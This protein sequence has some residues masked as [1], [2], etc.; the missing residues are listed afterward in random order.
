MPGISYRRISYTLS[1]HSTNTHWCLLSK[2]IKYRRY[3]QEEEGV[4]EQWGQTAKNL[5]ANLRRNVC[6]LVVQT[7]ERERKESGQGVSHE[8]FEMKD[9]KK[10]EDHEK[11]RTTFGTA[12][13]LVTSSA[14]IPG[15]DKALGRQNHIKKGWSIS[16]PFRDY[17]SSGLDTWMIQVNVNLMTTWWDY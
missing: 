8:R 4:W 7:E 14:M 17:L 15:R 13:G 12:G 3:P 1:I 10:Q 2:R 9:Y 6:F 11:N 5:K 16:S